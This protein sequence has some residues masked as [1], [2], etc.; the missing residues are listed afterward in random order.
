MM[1]TTAMTPTWKVTGG[2]CNKAG[3]FSILLEGELMEQDILPESQAFLSLEGGEGANRTTG[4]ARGGERLHNDD[5]TYMT[6]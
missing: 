4:V 5:D 3:H 6:S 1:A 2:G